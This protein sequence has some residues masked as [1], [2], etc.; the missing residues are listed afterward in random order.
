MTG[1][2]FSDLYTQIIIEE[3]IL[4]KEHRG[5]VSGP[6]EYRQDPSAFVW[7][8]LQPFIRE[9]WKEQDTFI[10]ECAFLRLA[11]VYMVEKGKRDHLRGRPALLPDKFLLVLLYALKN[12]HSLH[13]CQNPDCK[14]PYFIAARASQVYCSEACA[15]PAQRKAKKEWWDKHGEEARRKRREKQ[16]RGK[17]AK[18]KK[19]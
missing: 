19:A 16:E 9:V 12:V 14:R 3:E 13:Y 6:D 8:R 17:H 11:G 10:K 15:K 1:L 2:D 18:A 5:I 7:D 4:L